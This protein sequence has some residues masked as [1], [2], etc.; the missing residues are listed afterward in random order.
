MLKFDDR[1][2]VVV[3]TQRGDTPIE[4]VRVDDV[5]Y[6]FHSGE[7]LR[8]VDILETQVSNIYRIRY[9]DGRSDY[10]QEH[11][12]IC[13][14]KTLTNISMLTTEL[15][16]SGNFR[17]VISQPTIHYEVNVDHHMVPDP[18]I[19]GALLIHGERDDEHINLPL[20]RPS[21]NKFIV[22]K[23]RLKLG[24]KI[25]DNRIYFKYND[26]MDKLITWNEFF[27]NG[28]QETIPLEYRR[29][30]MK[31]RWKF[32]QGVFDVGF[33]KYHFSET[34][35]VSNPSEWKLKEVQRMLWSLGVLSTVTYD[36]T[37]GKKR[38][39]RLDVR[40]GSFDYPGY[41]YD[42]DHITYALEQKYKIQNALEP[43]EL[44]IQSMEQSRSRAYTKKLKL[45]QPCV[46]F[47]CDNFLPRVS[48]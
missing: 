26:G 17:T 13:L 34:I 29:A 38:E 3:Q 44:K 41:F 21:A 1:I 23:Y 7:S 47:L 12:T 8:V 4:N 42:I 32:I 45:E 33:D 18:Y 31:D 5:V 43:I 14:G 15:L 16:E 30:S 9:T 28:V 27:P 2:P 48:G 25:G 10:Y 19:A 46:P 24:H 37:L 22:N 40:S 20:D 11:E 36:S 35:G 6:S 39:Y